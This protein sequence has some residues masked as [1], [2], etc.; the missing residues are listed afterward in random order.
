VREMPGG[1]PVTERRSKACGRCE[2]QPGA[3]LFSEARRAVLNQSKGRLEIYDRSPAPLTEFFKYKSPGLPVRWPP[4][5]LRT[6][7][8]KETKKL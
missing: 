3:G 1:F 8:A 7:F 5:D 6:R 2:S 4:P